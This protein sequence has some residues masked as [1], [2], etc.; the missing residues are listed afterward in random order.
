MKCRTRVMERRESPLFG[1]SPPDG[2]VLD[3]AGC[4]TTRHDGLLRLGSV[5]SY[6]ETERRIARDLAV[7]RAFARVLL[8]K[9]RRRK[10]GRGRIR[11]GT[12][13]DRRA[14]PPNSARR[15]Q[16][17]K[18][19]FRDRAWACQTENPALDRARARVSDGIAQWEYGSAMKQLVINDWCCDVLRQHCAERSRGVAVS[20]EY[21]EDYK[22]W[23]FVIQSRVVDDGVELER[24]EST[25]AVPLS[26]SAQVIISYCPWCGA[27][28]R[29]VFADVLTS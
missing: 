25:P 5:G 26:L 21:Y 19:R 15:A 7:L 29:N 13:A 11:M 17:M 18:L 9:A 20:L 8:A 23:R 22:F 2:W 1:R 14:M 4:V 24:I 6:G 16:Q 12:R 3:A 27:R 10:E 28:L